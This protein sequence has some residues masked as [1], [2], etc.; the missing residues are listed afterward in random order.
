MSSLTVGRLGLL[1]SSARQSLRAL[2]IQSSAPAP[3]T[4]S[5]W[6]SALGAI[7]DSI[8]QCLFLQM[9]YT[10]ENLHADGRA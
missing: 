10:A 5:P 3:G 9:T 1:P 8:S 4:L 7:E 6:V 2:L